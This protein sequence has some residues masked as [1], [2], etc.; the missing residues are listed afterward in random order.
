[1][2]ALGI[3]LM[4]VALSIVSGGLLAPVAIVGT[5]ATLGGLGIFASY[6]QRGDSKK[7]QNFVDDLN[8]INDQSATKKP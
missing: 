3:T 1:M 8:E 7:L 2:M 5:V 4:A 6:Q